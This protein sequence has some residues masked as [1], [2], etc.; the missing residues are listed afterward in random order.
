MKDLTTI[1]I[2]IDSRSAETGAREVTLAFREMTKRAREATHGGNR[3]ASDER[4][5]KVLHL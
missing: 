3:K 5:R 2:T 4:S 1:P